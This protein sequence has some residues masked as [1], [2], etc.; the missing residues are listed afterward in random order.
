MKKYLILCIL[1]TGLSMGAFA[2]QTQPEKKERKEQQKN[3]RQELNLTDVQY[4]QVNSIH[5]EYR[6][7]I[8]V[9]RD[10][11]QLKQE[12]KKTQLR[13]LHKERSEKINQVLTLEQ[14]QKMAQQKRSGQQRK[15]RLKNESL[16]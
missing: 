3:M 8:K 4:E 7:K 14:Q 11:Q 13:N 12:E 9:T 10:D 15:N 2:Q 5:K 1:V 16:Q 6:E